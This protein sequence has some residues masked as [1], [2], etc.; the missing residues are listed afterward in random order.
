MFMVDFWEDM[1]INA[2]FFT[3][4]PKVEMNMFKAINNA[5]D[6]ALFADEKASKF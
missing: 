4:R 1:W 5:M 6:I 2:A 3:D